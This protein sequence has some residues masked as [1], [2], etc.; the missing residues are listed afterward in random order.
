MPCANLKSGAFVVGSLGQ[1]QKPFACLAVVTISVC[2][3]HKEYRLHEN[4]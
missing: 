3:L 1:I 2:L 4:E